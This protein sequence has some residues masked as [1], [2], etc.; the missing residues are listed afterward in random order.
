MLGEGHKYDEDGHSLEGNKDCEYVCQR[1]KSRDLERQNTY[2]NVCVTTNSL[3]G[4]PMIHVR[5]MMV[6]RETEDFSQYL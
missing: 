1:E 3:L 6:T 2:T 5:P 4:S